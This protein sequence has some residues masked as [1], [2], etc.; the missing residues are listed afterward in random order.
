MVQIKNSPNKEFIGTSSETKPQNGVP[1]MSLFLEV[2][3]GDVYY[4]SGSQWL[5][6]GGN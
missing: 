3:T 5:P 4:Y 6:K 1:E 2:D